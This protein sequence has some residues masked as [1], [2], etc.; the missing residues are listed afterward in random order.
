MSVHLLLRSGTSFDDRLLAP[1]AV[2]G[3]LPQLDLQDATHQLPQSRAA[4]EAPCQP[5]CGGG[6][7]SVW[8]RRRHH[9]SAAVKVL[10]GRHACH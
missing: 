7:M 10:P 1:R 5:G 3:L 9:P 2:Q 8:L 4:A 6:T